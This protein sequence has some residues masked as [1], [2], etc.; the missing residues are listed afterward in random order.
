MATEYRHVE[1]KFVCQV[2]NCC[3]HYLSQNMQ[4]LHN[5]HDIWGESLRLVL[6]FYIFHLTVVMLYRFLPFHQPCLERAFKAN[7]YTCAAHPPS[8]VYY[9]FSKFNK[10]LKQK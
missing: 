6:L 8:I 5:F 1:Y 3:K 9:A 4:S 2:F 10:P 7:N